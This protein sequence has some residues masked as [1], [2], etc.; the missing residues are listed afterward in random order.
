[1]SKYVND[2]IKQLMK[3]PDF[4]KEWDDLEDEFTMIESLIKARIDSGLTQN[5]L[6]EMTGISQADISRIEN[7]NA[8]PS[9]K[10]LQRIAKAL[11]KKLVIRF[12]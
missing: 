11:N 1:M 12:L 6:S 8:N 3:D 5:E 10:T 9:L 4:K 2:T 7:G